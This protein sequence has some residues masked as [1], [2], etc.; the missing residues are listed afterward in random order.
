VTTSVAPP[1]RGFVA[2]RVGRLFSKWHLEEGDQPKTLCGWS[3]PASAER[4]RFDEH[5]LG[6]PW[7]LCEHCYAVRLRRVR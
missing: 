1:A 3:I 5:L 7:D 6:D 4:R 2:W